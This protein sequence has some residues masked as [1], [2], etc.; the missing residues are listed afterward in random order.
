VRIL[1]QEC[2]RA[3]GRFCLAFRPRAGGRRTVREGGT[4]RLTP[5]GAVAQSVRALSWPNL[6]RRERPGS[7]GPPPAAATMGGKDAQQAVRAAVTP[8]TGRVHGRRGRSPGR[9]PVCAGPVGYPATLQGD[10]RRGGGIIIIIITQHLPIR[11]FSQH[12]MGS[13]APVN[14]R[15][16]CR[17]T[18]SESPRGSSRTTRAARRAP[19]AIPRAGRSFVGRSGS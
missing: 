3:G 11:I 2:R 13:H 7:G 4:P 16:T 9:A 10:S 6:D 14:R 8:S 12:R 15:R 1:R 18:R 17:Q 5:T 19:G